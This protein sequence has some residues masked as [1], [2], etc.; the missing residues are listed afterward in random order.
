MEGTVSPKSVRKDLDHENKFYDD[1]HVPPLFK[2]QV[3]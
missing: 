1:F 2:R 3:S